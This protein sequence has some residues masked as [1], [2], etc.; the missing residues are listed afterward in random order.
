L[1][2]G[3][4]CTV[5]I[6][7]GTPSSAGVAPATNTLNVTASNA[8][9]KQVSITTLTYGSLY[10]GGYVFSI[11]DTPA[12][13]LSMGEVKV[14]A[15]TNSSTGIIWASNGQS[16]Q[17]SEDFMPFISESSGPTYLAAQGAFN[18]EYT[19][20]GDPGYEYPAANEFTTCTGN[21]QGSCNT[22]NIILY[23]NRFITNF[24]V[25]HQPTLSLGVTNPSYYAVG[26]CAASTAGNHSD[27]YLPAICEMGYFANGFDAN[28]G[29]QSDPTTQ[30]MQSNLIDFSQSSAS[31]YASLVAANY[32]WASTVDNSDPGGSAWAQ[33]FDTPGS[34]S[35]QGVQD[36]DDN[37]YGVRCVR[38]FEA[39]QP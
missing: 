8:N 7:P 37:T 12:G 1:P 6:T 28:C 38:A 29:A 13:N 21:V 25:A 39:N 11:D 26:V 16:G 27:W 33:K 31:V 19:N 10:G 35:I 5:T 24:V 3:Q 4:S 18:A 36:K 17:Y 14:A 22:D 9:S 32:Y 23:Y 30:N 15:T 34:S 2:A 20:A